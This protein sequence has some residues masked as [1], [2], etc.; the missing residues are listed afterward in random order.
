M[1]QSCVS[2]RVERA[3]VPKSMVALCELSLS[4]KTTSNVSH[5]SH[6]SSMDPQGLN[7]LPSYLP[8][9]LI[10]RVETLLAT[11]DFPISP[12]LRAKVFFVYR[13]LACHLLSQRNDN[14]H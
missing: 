14:L 11:I 8:N 9:C 12:F 4:L 13:L 7:N 5:Q 1:W 3:I 2:M 6:A 10:L